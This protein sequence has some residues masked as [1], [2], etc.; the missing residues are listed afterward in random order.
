MDR[1][2]PCLQTFPSNPRIAHMSKCAYVSGLLVIIGVPLDISTQHSTTCQVRVRITGTNNSNIKMATRPE[3][4]SA[5]RIPSA[6]EPN[7]N[8]WLWHSELFEMSVKQPLYMHRAWSCFAS[9]GPS[10]ALIVTDVRASPPGKYS[11]T[12]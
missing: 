3:G 11:Q 8:L 4:K 1:F 12:T 5:Q 7:P 6:G 9:L 10:S 2:H